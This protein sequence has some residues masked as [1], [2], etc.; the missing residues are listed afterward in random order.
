MHPSVSKSYIIPAIFLN[1]VL[2]LMSLNTILSRLLPPI[3]VDTA[4][5][6]PPYSTFGPSAQHPHLNIHASENICWSYTILIVC[7]QLAAFGR[8]SECREAGK[9]KARMKR[10]R[11]RGTGGLRKENRIAVC[12]NGNGHANGS[13]GLSSGTPQ[14]HQD[15]SCPNKSDPKLWRL[16][17]K[18][19]YMTCKGHTKRSVKK[20]SGTRENYQ[21]G[22][23]PRP[24]PRLWYL[25]SDEDSTKTSDSEI[26]M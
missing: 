2:F 3:V 6:P 23:C 25:E 7:A 19:A 15:S 22:I 9:E 24:D 12:M 11:A 16:E 20:F 10:E 8:V 13:V 21:D 14:H 26:M 1:P 17:A 4:E 5:Q 18:T